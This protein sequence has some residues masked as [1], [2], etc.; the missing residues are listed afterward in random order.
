LSATD[1]KELRADHINTTDPDSHRIFDNAQI[2]VVISYWSVTDSARMLQITGSIYET[3]S[4]IR[5]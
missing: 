4:S 1:N 5:H 2:N 3:P